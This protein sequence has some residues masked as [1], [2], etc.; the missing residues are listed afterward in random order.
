[1]KEKECLIAVAVALIISSL[2][3][4][5]VMRGAPSDNMKIDRYCYEVERDGQVY[6]VNIK[7]GI[8]KK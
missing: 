3:A 8:V 7:G 5:H 1:M 4:M 6:I 2:I